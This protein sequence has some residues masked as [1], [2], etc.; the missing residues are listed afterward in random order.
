MRTL[1]IITLKADTAP[2]NLSRISESN[3]YMFLQ[4]SQNS[5]VNQTAFPP[6][7]FNFH[8]RCY[9]RK[10]KLVNGYMQGT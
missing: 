4:T 2:K 10:A 8:F 1:S 9:Y 7:C 6:V 5:S 3:K